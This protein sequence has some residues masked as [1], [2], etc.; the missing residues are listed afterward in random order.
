MK[1]QDLSGQ[2]FGKLVA[3]ERRVDGKW[4]C[5]CD[6]GNV[7]AVAIGNLKNGHTTSCGCARVESNHHRSMDLTDQRFGRLVV[8]ERAD[9][10]PSGAIRWKCKCD[11]GK[12]TVVAQSNLRMGH[13]QSCG[14]LSVETS[15][16]QSL[17]HGDAHVSRIYEIWKNMRSRCNNANNP[18][19]ANYGGRGISI[20]EEWSS[21][22]AFK[23]WAL[24]HG[25]ADNLSIDR[26]DVNQGYAPENCRWATAKT[27]SNNC[28]TNHVIEYQGTSYTLSQLAEFANLPVSTLYNRLITLGWDIDRA[29]SVPARSK[30]KGEI[31]NGSRT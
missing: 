23:A 29:V 15:R 26:I 13:T 17:I 1:K 18:A 30:S 27:Q 28:R 25:Y 20:C 14:C 16:K 12:T 9:R 10:T 8:I 2:R 6:C 7:I 31:T 4:L 21:Y 22:P 24:S 11:C 3:I 5:K 19:Y